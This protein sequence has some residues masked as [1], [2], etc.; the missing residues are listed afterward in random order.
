MSGP[1]RWVV[2]LTLFAVWTAG[3]L[4]SGVAQVVR[5]NLPSQTRL[6]IAKVVHVAAYALLT[7][8]A[9]FLPLS[10]RW[11]WLVLLVLSGHAILTEYL[12]TFIPLR[13]GQWQ[14]AIL[15]HIGISLGLLLVWPWW[16]GGSRSWS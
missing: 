10:G 13:T 8:T 4:S 14:D 5:H 1:V 3:L 9:A 7:A 6:P 11:R 12:Q 16:L 2:W 15:N